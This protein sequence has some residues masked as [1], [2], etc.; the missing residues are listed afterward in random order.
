MW[1]RG[2][3]VVRWIEVFM[4]HTADLLSSGTIHRATTDTSH[5][6]A[7]M[8]MQ[9]WYEL[10]GELATSLQA[11]KD[12]GEINE[13]NYDFALYLITNGNTYDPIEYVEHTLLWLEL[14]R[15]DD[16]DAV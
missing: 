9:R 6:L 12:G 15:G 4:L 8:L 14:V 16:V 11:A 2:D 1:I 7:A 3:L 13:A 5:P 10:Q